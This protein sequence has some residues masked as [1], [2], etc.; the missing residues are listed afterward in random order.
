MCPKPVNEVFFLVRLSFLVFVCCMNLLLN[1]HNASVFH[2]NRVGESVMSVR[3][4]D[5][6]GVGFG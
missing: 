4:G 1:G 6:N 3:F 2:E 5:E